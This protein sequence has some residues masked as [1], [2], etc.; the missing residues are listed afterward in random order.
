MIGFEFDRATGKCLSPEERLIMD[1]HDSQSTSL[2]PRFVFDDAE[3]PSPPNASVSPLLPQH[4]QLI[5]KSAISSEV[6]AERGYRSVTVRA[7]LRRLGFTE[8]QCRVPAL[9]IP[10][11][12]ITGQVVLYQARP[13]VP[14]IVDGKPI[15]YETPRGSHMV[16]DV[17]Q[18]VRPWLADPSRPLFITEGARKADAAASK[19]LA[20]VSLLGVWNW[21]GT[22][23]D[24]GK[25][26]L[27][28]WESVALNGRDALIVFDS[29]VTTKQAVRGALKRLVT[30]L[31]SR[32]AHPKIVHLPHDASGAKVG[33]D[34]FLSS[35]H[36]VEDLLNLV[37]PLPPD[38]SS[39]A[40]CGN[41]QETSEG[42][43][44]LKNTK[45]GPMPVSLT[46]FTARIVS[47]VE[48]NDGVEV[49]RALRI[50][51][52]LRN[53]KYT[54]AVPAGRFSSM[55][56]PMEHMGAAAI[57]YP[58][59]TL[60]DHARAAIQLLSGAVQEERV[61][62]HAGWTSTTE[63]FIYLHAGGA[64]GAAGVVA[65]INVEVPASLAPFVLPEPPTGV[66]LVKAIRASL[67]LLRVAPQRVTIPILGAVTRSVL[68]R[69]DFSLYLAGRTQV[70][71]SELAALAQQY[72]GQGFD[73][74]HLPASWSSTGNSLEALA[75]VAKDAILVI[76]DFCPSGS[77][78]DVQRMHRE[79]DRLFRA[80]GNSS[81]RGRLSSD[82][83]IRSTKPPRGLVLSTGED[84]PRGQSLRARM[85][86][87]EVGP[88][89]VDF[90]IL[91][92]A[93]AMAAEGLFAAAM[94]GY[95]RWVAANHGMITAELKMQLPEIRAEA[96][97]AGDHRRTPG[98]VANLY[99]GLCMYLEFALEVGAI[100]AKFK[101]DL[102]ESAW[103][104]LGRVAGEQGEQQKAAEPVQ[105]FFDLLRAAITAGEAHVASP[106]GHEPSS[107]PE[108]WGWREQ[109]FGTGE[110]ERTD[111]RP[112]RLRVGWVVDDDL[113]LDRD[114]A[115]SACQ[116]MVGPNGD[117]L[118]IAAHTLVKRLHERRLLKST[119][120]ER[121]SLLVRRVL[122]GTRRNV[123]HLSADSVCPPED[124]PNPPTDGEGNGAEGG[125][126]RGWPKD[127]Y[128]VTED[129]PR[130]APSGDVGKSMGKWAS[131]KDALAHS[132]PHGDTGLEANGQDGQVD[133]WEEGSITER[134]R[135]GTLWRGDS[136][137]LRK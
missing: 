131:E 90:E 110:N 100:N 69:V 37:A 1:R 70:G 114:A 119:E 83:T 124:L 128:P 15:K 17:P 54:F 91:T 38:D 85:F 42:L 115:Y 13:D 20:C 51:S 60:K 77:M 98:I 109:T 81:G 12:G 125:C 26:A 25:T 75:F 78:S 127:D 105:R 53:R 121:G 80:Q 14:R 23:G 97:R 33:L 22:N 9:L 130:E 132:N 134:A 40:T 99:F 8:T 44:L 39:A 113:Y 45:D 5:D 72:F 4:Q 94:A 71:K 93:Q 76:D 24:G 117:G 89:D 29:D 122:E 103:K 129:H 7:E 126:Q 11:H 41:Y 73:R 96:T 135:A 107:N 58:G 106:S 84:V 82:G 59:Q 86:V 55:S 35:D 88:G 62:T 102:L 3:E 87:I 104:T 28:D 57:V 10:I 116:R 92:Q 61:F 48:R 6:S 43:I 108:A 46:N 21:R 2:G 101:K 79:A 31:E 18:R 64:I 52:Q 36:T 111:W 74:T 68:A 118:T 136:E 120:E 95:L 19:G 32:K 63:G 27:G 50:E 137:G 67:E 133:L 47:D 34:D 112:E 66:E 123:I 30:F 49:V 16:L 65:D 56:W